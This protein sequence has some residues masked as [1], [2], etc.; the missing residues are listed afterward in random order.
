MFFS[1]QAP[2]HPLFLILILETTGSL[3]DISGPK[4]DGGCGMKEIT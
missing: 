3:A 4:A 2:H 1:Y